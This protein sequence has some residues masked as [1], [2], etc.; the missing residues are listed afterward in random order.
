[1]G[2]DSD[3]LTPWLAHCGRVIPSL[4]GS[5]WPRPPPSASRFLLCTRGRAMRRGWGGPWP[6]KERGDFHCVWDNF[7]CDVWECGIPCWAKSV[8]CPDSQIMWPGS[9]CLNLS[10]GVYI[11]IGS[12]T[13]LWRLFFLVFERIIKEARNVQSI[14]K[15]K[16]VTFKKKKSKASHGKIGGK[17]DKCVERFSV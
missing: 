15:L 7:H 8:P 17:I 11:W 1:M 9:S 3:M 16:P 4:Q 12:G 10:H 5:P 14:G 13:K 2:F 6:I